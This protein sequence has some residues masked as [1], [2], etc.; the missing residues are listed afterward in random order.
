MVL[1][2]TF[3][4][5]PPRYRERGFVLVLT[6]VLLVVL[7][8]IGVSAL[9]TTNLQEKM[10][11]NI[12]EKMLSEQTADAALVL[13]ERWVAS[14]TIEDRTQQLVPR[15]DAP[16]GQNDGLYTASLDANNLPVW[17]SL[18]WT[19]TSDVQ[20]YPVVPFASGGTF[21][22]SL[23]LDPNVISRPP[24]FIIEQ[25]QQVKC[26]SKSVVIGRGSSAECWAYRITARGHGAGGMGATIAQ[27]TVKKRF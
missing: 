20:Q 3:S 27:T 24:R 19:S 17:A 16:V 6:L 11:H 5:P 18:N 10:A 26:A 12:K 1:S 2:P 23:A 9:S 14:L 22:A 13:A 15:F 7:T 4:A 8:L 21:T 25:V